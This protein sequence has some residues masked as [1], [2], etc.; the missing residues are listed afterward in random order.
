MKKIKI[1]LAILV[2]SP[3][4]HAQNYFD[5]L[6]DSGYMFDLTRLIATLIGI[7]LVSAFILSV[8]KLIFDHR[9]KRRLIDKGTSENVVSQLLM[10]GRKDNRNI[11]IKWAVIFAG[12]GAG[13]SLI[14]FFQPFGLHSLAIMSFCIAG[15]FW[16]YYFLTRKSEN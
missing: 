8:I 13:L 2:T 12:I 9:I 16:A 3:A 15:S 4:L 5:P 10:P 6:K 14:D 1:L 11:A 7:F